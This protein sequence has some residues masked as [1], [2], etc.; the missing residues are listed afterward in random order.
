MIA[1]AGYGVQACLALGTVLVIARLLPAPEFSRYSVIAATAQ[2]AAVLAFEWIRIGAMRFYP[3]ADN[4]SAGAERR[5]IGVLFPRA[6]L[7]LG[8]PAF[9]ISYFA[10]GLTFATLILVLAIA[11][12]MSDLHMTLVRFSGQ[13]PRFSRMQLARSLLLFAGTIVAGY[14]GGTAS[15]ALFGLLAGHVLALGANLLFNPRDG[16]SSSEPAPVADIGKYVRYGMPAATASVLHSGVP[17]GVRA[18]LIG[19]FGEAG[20]AGLVLALDLFQRPLALIAVALNGVLYP[21]VVR[22]HSH[23][24][25]ASTARQKLYVANFAALAIGGGLL[26]VF[27]GELASIAVRD[28]IR[29]DFILAAPWLILFFLLRSWTQNVLSV[30]WHLKIRPWVLAMLGAADITLC[31]GAMALVAAFADIAPLTLMA[32]LTLAAALLTC[33]ALAA[34]RRY[35]EPLPRPLLAFVALCLPLYVLIGMVAP[36][37]GA[38]SMVTKAISALLLSASL[39]LLARSA[40]KDAQ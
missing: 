3:G 21:D 8:I 31:L 7:A 11:Q 18:I 2:F 25:S 16:K 13:L 28:D 17:L 4:G 35:R 40:W 30:R 27:A 9:A 14:S 39:T 19:L 22:E 10:V 20:A 6:A 32:A 23:E 34:Q 5:A 24:P 1:I 29:A 36:F 38:V 37:Q 12:A 33:L 26:I 15:H